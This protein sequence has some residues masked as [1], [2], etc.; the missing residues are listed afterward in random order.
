MGS[1]HWTSLLAAAATASACAPKPCADCYEIRA[2]DPTGGGDDR[3]AIGDSCVPP[4]W[5]DD[6]AVTIEIER[7][8]LADRI[9]RTTIT[10]GEP[11]DLDGGAA[12][13]NP[14]GTIELDELTYSVPHDMEIEFSEAD[15]AVLL[16]VGCAWDSAADRD[17]DILFR[18][19]RRE[20]VDAWAQYRH[21]D[22]WCS[23]EAW[24]WLSPTNC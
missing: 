6:G 9:L 12:P 13:P 11:Y 10:C 2:M 18:F 5:F 23:D 19:D 8:D 17:P 4:G 22:N 20:E 3:L 15:P 24:V 21:C 7:V 1:L 16:L 14:E